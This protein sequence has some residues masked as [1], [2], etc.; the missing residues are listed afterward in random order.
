M[1]AALLVA[2]LG[3]AQEEEEVF[4]LSPFTVQGQDDSGYRA[5]STLAG[6]RIRTNLNDVGSA[7]SVVT[8]EFLRDTGATDTES[9]LVYTMGTEVAGQNGNFAGGGDGGRV[10]SDDQRRAPNEATRVR[11]LAAA[12]NTRSFFATNIPWDSY[13]VDRLDIQRGPNSV[14]FGLGSPAGV[15]NAM[16][17]R[18]MFADQGELEAKF[19]SHG[20]WRGTLD[21]NKVLIEDELAVRVSL[22]KE[23]QRFKQDGAFEEDDRYFVSM[24]WKPSFLQSDS[25]GGQLSIDYEEGEIDANRPRVIPPIDRIT[26]WF[27]SMNKATYAATELDPSPSPY[28]GNEALGR[29]FDGPVAV[30][31]GSGAP[32]N[33]FM[34]T[35]TGGGYFRGIDGFDDYAKQAQLD[36]N[37][38]VPTDPNYDLPAYSI[39]GF[40]SKTLDDPTI[41]D[42]YNKL[43]DGPNKREW[44]EWDTHN[45]TY[46]HNWLDNR[47]GLELA[48]D[49]QSYEDGQANVLDNFGQAISIDL[50]TV[51]PDG[52]DNSANVGR[53]IVG[54]DAQNNNFRRIDRDT[55]RVTGYFEHDFRDGDS[56]SMNWLGRH[57]F[58][59]LYADSEVDRLE[60]KWIRNAA[61][62]VNDD[63]SITA[64]A[65]YVASL[66]YLG[67]S[68][69]D[70]ASASGANIPALSSPLVPTGGSIVTDDGTV[71]MD[72]W[73]ADSGDIA[74]LYRQANLAKDEVESLAFVWQG[75][76]FDGTVVPM[77]GYRDDT[78]KAGNAGDAFAV[79]GVSGA[80]DPFDSS[81]T[82]PGSKSA[83]TNSNS[84]F[85]KESGISRTYSLVLHAPES[86]KRNLP[87]GMDLSL[88]YGESSNFRPDASRRDIRGGQIAPET[89]E[90]K[91]YALT[92]SALEGKFSL[93]VNRYETKV[94]GSTLSGSSIANSYMIGA[95]EGW[96]R[97]YTGWALAAEQQG[98]SGE[99]SG[100]GNDFWRN[101]A[102]E[103]PTL[104]HSDTNPYI[105]PEVT[106]LRYEPLSYTPE[107]VAAAKAAQ[108]AVFDAVF[109]PANIPDEAIWSFWG[110]NFNAF[111]PV[112]NPGGDWAYAW[113][114][115]PATFAVTSDF[116]SKGWE[117]ELFYQPTDNWNIVLNAAKTEAKRSNIADSYASYVEERWELY[118]GAYGDMRIWG[119]WANAE[120][121]GGK[122][123]AE[124]YSNYLLN[125]LLNDS[126]VP[127]LRPWRFNVV[128]NYSFTDG[129]LAGLNVGG[130]LRW[131]DDVVVGYGITT[132]EDGNPIYDVN[133]PYKGSSETNVD[134][135]A[136]YQTKLSDNVDWRIQLNVQNAF[137]GDELIPITV[138]IDGTPATS[139]IAPSRTWTISNTF[140]F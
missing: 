36:Q 136:G 123:G 88:S 41:F 126:D 134:F 125:T 109:N 48:L 90:T 70:R 131:Q 47:L 93:K 132:D 106:D 24:N 59:G 101:F 66:A 71:N 32:S 53:P 99:G 61:V 79:S 7:I 63:K 98:L 87:E 124:F 1:G 57:V 86:L 108:Q 85:E 135:W 119:P 8:E 120:T 122:Y 130:A 91:E 69:M 50:V 26:P 21:Y 29:I 100:N 68:L 104:P 103:D 19:G 102:L 82:V 127:E 52:T 42:F 34:G 12:D 49:S 77:F 60:A 3:F 140:S 113:N 97:M 111:D 22:L 64:A 31:D 78:A 51:L 16:V 76:L 133:R 137:T 38:R 115:E 2:P 73:S 25:S 35:L 44:Q 84:Y 43:L 62:N 45:V 75:F 54:G 14:L 110:Q 56:E 33:Y 5:T 139:R 114:G 83:V 58:T 23:D 20:T 128:T 95:G 28:I 118:Q 92:V 17:N 27:D 6:T 96:G 138:N 9:L 94:K 55:F 74:N 18:A 117:Y 80:V 67:P 4:D 39:G 37:G 13:N 40:K 81:W 105:N 89:G 15:I 72:V 116:V 65:R 112:N 46:A 10:D 30:Y 129:K 107:G 121:V 11:G